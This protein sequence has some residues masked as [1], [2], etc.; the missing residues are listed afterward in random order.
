M[1]AN[2]FYF[3]CGLFRR[4]KIAAFLRKQPKSDRLL[5]KICISISINIGNISTSG[6]LLSMVE[7]LPSSEKDKPAK[8]IIRFA[9]LDGIRGVT[10]LYVAAFHCYQMQLFV[11]SEVLPT[12]TTFFRIFKPLC[13][14]HYAVAVFIVL[15][16][17]C[18]MLPIAIAGDG[19]R[20]KDGL[21][22]YFARRAR[23]IIPPFY[24]AVLLTIGLLPVTRTIWRQAIETG[25]P[26]LQSLVGPLDQSKLVYQ[27]ISHLCLL[28][29]GVPLSD[30]SIVKFA[31]N[32]PLWSVATE[33]QIY[34]LFPAL[35]LPILRRFGP[36]ASVISGIGIGAILS[37][38][39]DGRYQLACPWMFGVFSI[40]VL[41]ALISCSQEVIYCR[42]RERI[43]WNYFGP[44]ILAGFLTIGT[45]NLGLF[46]RNSVIV[47][48]C[49]GIGIMCCLI[50]LSPKKNERGG[51]IVTI[52][53]DI[54]SSKLCDISQETG[55]ADFLAARAI[56][57]LRI[58]DSNDRTDGAG[59]VSCSALKPK[60][61][62]PCA[63]FL[64]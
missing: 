44:V 19:F 29:N 30:E 5:A 48:T 53:A 33:S 26:T 35:L 42:L 50:A 11:S 51:R 60:I 15:S 3:F 63:P 57:A 59:S 34:I 52:F 38:V 8:A 13:M 36:W 2:A 40:G 10:A 49:L 28:N 24:A 22:G 18:L 54:L 45:I 32:T 46:R 6:P 55:N 31:S 1:P 37:F 25:K 20:M 21:K 39:F 56:C 23:R 47:D 58:M 64:H 4:L 41:G 61:K 43:P 12:R 16:G 62:Q 7:R 14:G 17:Y 9:Y 27:L